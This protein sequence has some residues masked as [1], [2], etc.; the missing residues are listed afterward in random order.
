MERLVDPKNTICK[1]NYLVGTLATAY[2]GS[3]KS[4]V[5]KDFCMS[6]DVKETAL[7]GTVLSIP[8]GD[9]EASLIQSGVEL[10]RAGLRN[11]SFF[12]K[13]STD[14]IKEDLNLQIDV[15]QSGRHIGTFLMKRMKADGS[16]SSAVELSEELAGK[17][18][19][20]LTIPLRDKVGLLLKAEEIVS[21]AHS[22][23][24]DWVSFSEKLSGF[25]QDFYWSSADAFCRAFDIIAHYMLIAAEH[26]SGDNQIKALSNYFDLLDLIIENEH[27]Q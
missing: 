12:L 8:E 11:G 4:L 18:F 19:T 14:R 23:K 20:L 26:I 24:K 7:E 3:I 6:E 13:T 17:D 10:A 25:S 27:D 22:T 1:L 2:K 15:I 9:Y 16:Y 21:Y 5:A